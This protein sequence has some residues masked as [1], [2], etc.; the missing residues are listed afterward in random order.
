[1]VKYA[2]TFYGH[3]AIHRTNNTL[4]DLAEL[5]NA[6]FTKTYMSLYNF[7]PLKPHFV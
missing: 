3:K 5:E 4:S 2:E 6:S 1:M 7:D